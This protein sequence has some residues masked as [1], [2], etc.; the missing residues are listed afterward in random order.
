MAET[1]KLFLNGE[2]VASEQRKQYRFTTH[3]MGQ[4]SLQHPYVAHQ[5]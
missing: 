4:K 5:K 2:W 1:V 3:L